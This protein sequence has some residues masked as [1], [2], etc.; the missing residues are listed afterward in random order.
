M[1]TASE[2]L[3][4]STLG[5]KLKKIN[6]ET[7]MMSPSKKSKKNVYGSDSELSQL[8]LRLKKMDMFSLG[9]SILEVLNDGRSPMNYTDLLKMG[10][11]GMDFS[12]IIKESV[13]KLKKGSDALSY[14]ILNLLK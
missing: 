2:T 4:T 13:A 8:M 7:E 3:S 9:L 1:A 10:K 14:I 12:P 6:S 11:E 5:S